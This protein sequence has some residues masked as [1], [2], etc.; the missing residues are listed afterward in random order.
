MNGSKKKLENAGKEEIH[1]IN[2][3]FQLYA[4]NWSN[5]SEEE[6]SNRLAFCSQNNSDPNYIC[7]K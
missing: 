7:V 3:P 4:F 2:A 5:R 1:T 6:Y